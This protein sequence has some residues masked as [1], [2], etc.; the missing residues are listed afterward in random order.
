[1]SIVTTENENEN[2]QKYEVFMLEQGRKVAEYKELL[3]S[4]SGSRQ[5]IIEEA[6]RTY[7]LGVGLIC[8]SFAVTFLNILIIL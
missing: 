3:K 5:I 4:M 1:M 7:K 6:L 8:L 2:M